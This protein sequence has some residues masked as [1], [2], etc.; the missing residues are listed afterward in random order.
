MLSFARAY[1]WLLPYIA[2]AV[3]LGLFLLRGHQ[4]ADT[5]EELQLERDFRAEIADTLGAPAADQ[6][7]VRQAIA[8]ALLTSEN[9]RA[10][11]ERIDQDAAAAKER[12]DA[13]EAELERRQEQYQ[14]A[15]RAAQPRIVELE[16]R[17][18]SGDELLDQRQLE[19][20]SKAPWRGWK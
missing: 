11:L 17:K 20:D 3:L 4:L 12:A 2:I 13:A 19:E 6:K 9:R 5:R 1:A 10:A 18:P 7:T 15:F 8:A 16:Q 14:R